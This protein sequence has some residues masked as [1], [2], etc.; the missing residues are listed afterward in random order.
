M[1]A[2]IISQVSDEIQ[3]VATAAGDSA[4]L[5]AAT[6]IVLFMTPGLALFYGGLDES[7][8]VTN[9]MSMNFY[10]LGIVPILWVLFGHS[11][12]S[13]TFGGGNNAFIGDGENF[14]LNDMSHPGDLADIAFAITFAVIAP[15][16]ISGAVAGRMKFGAWLWFVPLWL[17]LVYVP[18]THWVFADGGWIRDLPSHDWAGGTSIHINAGVAALVLSKVLGPRRQWPSSQRPP[19]NLPLVAMGTGILLLGWFGFNAGAGGVEV[20]EGIDIGG[21]DTISP[22]AL[23]NT[24]LAAAGGLVGW[25]LVEHFSGVKP[26]IVGMCSGLV[27]ALVAITPGCAFVGPLPAI[28]IGFV[29]SMFCYLALGLKKRFNYDDSLDVVGIHGVGGI[30]GALMIGIFADNSVTTSLTTAIA[31]RTEDNGFF[32]EGVFFGGNGELL[33]NQLIGVGATI[34][35]SAVATFVIAMVL[36]KTIGL[37][38]N[39]ES[40]IVGL[41][42]AEH[43]SSSYII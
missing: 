12:A 17:I 34:G 29:A 41:D 37:R 36:K 16:L 1:I 15:A 30:I 28:L 11:L 39:D 25:V 43:S 19:H 22:V 6:A 35:Y 27:A 2:Q 26:N 5:L 42:Q 33:L 38:V 31:E 14:F 20:M 7:K 21:V 23:T 32:V 8:N 40:Q 18:V 24:M 4:W 13:G 10:C 3:E 9:M